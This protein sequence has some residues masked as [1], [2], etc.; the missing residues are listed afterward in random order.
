MLLHHTAREA[1]RGFLC[2]LY[3]KYCGSDDGRKFQKSLPE[4]ESRPQNPVLIILHSVIGDWI[5]YRK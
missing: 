1:E 5:Q 4:I 2:R 3:Q